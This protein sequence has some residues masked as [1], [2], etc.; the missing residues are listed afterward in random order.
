MAC[1]RSMKGLSKGYQ[2]DYQ[3]TKKL[4]YTVK[5]LEIVTDL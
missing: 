3:N 2:K 1:K 5:L 4:F